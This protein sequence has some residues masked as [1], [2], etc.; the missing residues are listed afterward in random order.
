MQFPST[1]SAMIELLASLGVKPNYITDL[2]SATTALR[3]NAKYLHG[4]ELRSGGFAPSLVA[5]LTNA[6]SHL[7]K[8]L[9]QTLSTWSGWMSASSPS[10][11]D[12]VQAETISRWVVNQYPRRRYPAVMIGSSNG[13]AVHLGA[14]L[15]IPWLPQ[16]L[17]ISLRHPVDPDEPKQELEWAKAPAQRLL[18]RNPDLWVYQMHDPN[19]DR[20]K[21]PRVTYFR[22]KR[23]RLGT[24]FKQ[25]LTENLEPG[26]TLFLLECQY[27]WLSTHVADRHVFQFGGKGELAPEDYFQNSQQISDFLQQ[28]GS[29]HRYWEPPAPDGRLPE[30][31]WGFEPAL[32]QDVEQFARQYGFRIRRI[33]FDYPQDLSPL[34]ADLYRWWY[35][36]RGLPSDRLLVESFVYLQPWW[37]LRLGLVPFWTVFNDRMSAMR[38][39]NYLD[40]AK[41]YDEIYMT[42]FSNGLR[43]LGQASLDEWRSILSRARDR[44]QFIGVNE[45]TYPGDLGSY[46]RH[47]TDL[48]KLDRR[49]PMPEPLTLQQLDSFL[50]QAG[51]RY[52]ARWIDHPVA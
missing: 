20:L 11:L 15:G 48:K 9:G 50:A 14:A 36:E 12:D 19:Q 16:T 18:A 30:S 42:L 51:D 43:A 10:I 46:T 22:I 6:V 8:Q 25:F 35:Q 33:V 41:P 29:S 2:D 44:G 5:S 26:A 47:Y 34:V 4:K 52:S 45:Q 3:A 24:R 49:Y 39:N 23:A 7:P 21:V 17:L 37:A 1:Y 28:Q 32:R 31:E 13:A 38:L 40:T 27:N